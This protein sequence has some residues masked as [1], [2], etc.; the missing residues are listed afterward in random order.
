[1]NDENQFI[2]EVGVLI[3]RF[4]IGL[5]G[6]AEIDICFRDNPNNER[7]YQNVCRIFWGVSERYFSGCIDTWPVSV[8]KDLLEIILLWE[9]TVRGKPW[10]CLFVCIRKTSETS[11]FN[12]TGRWVPNIRTFRIIRRRGLKRLLRILVF[13]SLKIKAKILCEC[14]FISH[15][16]FENKFFEQANFFLGW[17]LLQ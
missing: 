11:L 14:G 7:H 9:H 8:N 5:N 2:P 13:C 15:T 3:S 6:S 1:M 12:G 16:E 17:R 10:I 4:L